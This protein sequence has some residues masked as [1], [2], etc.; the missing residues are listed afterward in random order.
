MIRIAPRASFFPSCP[1]DADE[2]GAG[3]SLKG[4]CTGSGFFI[5]LYTSSSALS[6][7]FV[8][9]YRVTGPLITRT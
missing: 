3:A 8:P 6:P 1:H 9:A 4:L 2:S 7:D 5:V